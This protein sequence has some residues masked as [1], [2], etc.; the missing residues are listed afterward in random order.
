MKTASHP[1]AKPTPSLARR[2]REK[3]ETRR[4]ILGAARALFT[5][6]GYESTTMRAIATRIGYTATAIY[7][8]FA[9]KE[10]LM[11]ELCA[12]D[13][14]EMGMALRSIGKIADPIERI[15]QMGRAYIRFALEHP[16]QFRF[17]FLI[18]RPMPG[19]EDVAHLMDPGHDGY[20]FLLE[21]VGE[22][23]TGGHFRPELQDPDMIAQVFW[24]AVHGIAT[25]HV[26]MPPEKHKWVE[27]RD[28][29]AT[30]DV[31]CAAMMNGLLREP[32]AASR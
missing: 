8:H 25:I 16:E 10:A 29:L 2:E 7:H 13:F 1:S 9:D 30:A 24:G 23:M 19:P 12:S 11:M 15:R 14:N 20:V 28:A 31:C 6:E 32:V 5:R 3:A 4:L 26:C 22:A 17:M 21:A 18:D 27:L